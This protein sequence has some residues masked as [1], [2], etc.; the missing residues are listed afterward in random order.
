MAAYSVLLLVLL[1]GWWLW[2]RPRWMGLEGR[3]LWDWFAVTVEPVLIAVATVL[4]TTTQLQ[5]QESRSQEEAVQQFL[6]RVDGI[7]TSEAEPVA[8]IALARAHTAAIL[9]LTAGE[10]AGRVL[11]FLDEVGLL[12]E[13]QANLEELDL[14]G[15]TLK[16]L[17]LD[18]LDLE[19]SILRGVDLEDSSLVGTDLEGA[20]L[21]DAD[22]KFTDLRDADVAGADLSGALLREADLRGADLRQVRGLTAGQLRTACFDGSTQLPDAGTLPSVEAEGC[23]GD[24]TDEDDD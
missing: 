1:A 20:D 11:V 10:R 6:D 14:A 24:G 5:V 19:G 15:A 16:G 21:R 12:Q 4:I 2:R 23:D 13:S 22:L 3:T 7:M 8:Q 18:G 17:D 9:Q